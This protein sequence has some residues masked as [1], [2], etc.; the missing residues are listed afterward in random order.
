MFSFSVPPSVPFIFDNWPDTCITNLM[1]NSQ[2][3][4]DGLYW[5][6]SALRCIFCNCN[7]LNYYSLP[8][9]S[10]TPILITFHCLWQLCFLSTS[11][12]ALILF[13]AIL[14]EHIFLTKLITLHYNFYIIKQGSHRSWKTWKVMEFVISMSRSGKSWNLR[15]GHGK[16]W[17]SIMLGKKI[18]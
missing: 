8:L 1:V 10:V 4:R 16:S 11:G 13:L 7:K 14:S 18:F 9:E 15:E 3:H 5:D 17:K 12:P 2:I 6:L